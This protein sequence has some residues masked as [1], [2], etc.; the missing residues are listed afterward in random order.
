MFIFISRK[1]LANPRP[2]KL[3]SLSS[4]SKN[5]TAVFKRF[6]TLFIAVVSATAL[7]YFLMGGPSL[8]KRM[9]QKLWQLLATCNL[10]FT[11]GL[12][13]DLFAESRGYTSARKWVLRATVVMLCGLLYAVLNPALHRTDVVR[14]GL[15]IFAFHHL[16]AFAPFIK[17]G[18]NSDFWHFNKVLF[19]RFLTATLYSA[20]LYAGLTMAIFGVEKLFNLDLASEIYGQLFVLIG[21][22]FNTL[23]FLAGVPTVFETTTATYPK[24]LKVFT[25]YVLIPLMTTYLAILL[26]YELKILIE[27]EMPKGIV[28]T[29][30]L[31]YAVFGM[32]S[33]LLV[34]PIRDDDGSRWVRL[35]SKSFYLTLIPLIVLL[36]LA[37][38]QRVSHYGFTEERHI[39]MVLT[40]WLSAIA[41]YFLSFRRGDIQLI[42]VSLAVLALLSTFGPQSATDISRRSQQRRLAKTLHTAPQNTDERPSIVTYLLEA[43]GI[44]SLQAFTATDLD[45]LDREIT[46]TNK[47]LPPY[48]INWLKRDSLFVLLDIPPSAMT[49]GRHLIIRR[50]GQTV[51]PIQ[52]YDYGYRIEPYQSDSTTITLGQS[53]VWISV[54]QDSSLA[55]K[56][57]TENDTT[58]LFDLSPLLDEIYRAHKEGKLTPVENN[59]TEFLYPADKM[60]IQQ[61]S[62]HFTLTLLLDQVNGNFLAPHSDSSRGIYITGYLLFKEK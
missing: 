45:S 35:F 53:N 25:Q 18:G 36:A 34:W 62:A 59:E 4:L 50:A 20:F 61:E 31:G 7:A 54:E 9:E 60:E 23:F 44:Q 41:V 10:L 37:V 43:H 24:G 33:L 1:R 46:T 40:L 19:L 42:P 57:T 48:Q 39:L 27:W 58:L 3:P 12:A 32:L 8:D 17:H 47:D 56:V 15:F 30:I 6:P 38:Y 55:V 26:V 49:N 22:G 21:I 2:M 51:I 13:A 14:I 11:L 29:L 52:G 16:V 28:A 5:A